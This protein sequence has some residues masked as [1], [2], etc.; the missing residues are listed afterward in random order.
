MI[1][2]FLHQVMKAAVV[3]VLTAE[4]AVMK[5][6]R[7]HNALPS[8][9]ATG[10]REISCYYKKKKTSGSMEAL[11]NADSIRLLIQYF[12]DLFDADLLDSIVDQSN[13]YCT[14]LNWNC[15]LKLDHN[16]LEQF[17]CSVMYM[18]VLHLPGPV[19]V[20][21]HRWLM[22]V[23]RKMGW[24]KTFHSFQ[25]HSTQKWWKA[26]QNQATYWFTSPPVSGSPSRS[27]GCWAF[28]IQRNIRSEAI[29]PQEYIQMGIQNLCA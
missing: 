12:R 25:W 7:N 19:Q 6:D 3:K 10:K 9:S 20:E 13:L 5:T 22:W 14:R 1:S 8:T 28:A 4:A 26:F 11:P 16:D 27:N 18:S 21:N 24:N 15:A 29:H 23:L 17:I 2:F